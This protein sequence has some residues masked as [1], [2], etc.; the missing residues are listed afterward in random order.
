MYHVSCWFH[1][2]GC[3][4]S[5]CLSQVSHRGRKLVLLRWPAACGDRTWRRGEC[6]ESSVRS[7]A[8]WMSCD[9]LSHFQHTW[10]QVAV[11]NSYR[12]VLGWVDKL[13]ELGR[14][15]DVQTHAD[16]RLEE[17]EELPWDSYWSGSLTTRVQGCVFSATK[18]GRKI[19]RGLAMSCLHRIPNTVTIDVKNH[20]LMSTRSSDSFDD[21]NAKGLEAMK[22]LLVLERSGKPQIGGQP[23]KGHLQELQWLHPQPWSI[24]KQATFRDWTLNHLP[25]LSPSTSNPPAAWLQDKEKYPRAHIACLA[26][27][28]RCPAKEDPSSN[29]TFLL[30]SLGVTSCEA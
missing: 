13:L 21:S 27:E 15:G 28:A 19:R 7:D 2:G 3:C 24:R 8:K 11:S 14:F 9:G 29:I 25:S 1:I 17:L 22:L 16:T 6:V 26:G 20:S 18:N 30:L 5:P 4:M 12:I 10:F 23:V